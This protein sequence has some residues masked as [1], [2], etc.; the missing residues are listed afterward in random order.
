MSIMIIGIQIIL[1]FFHSGLK[2]NVKNR[3]RQHL[4]RNLTVDN[5]VK[6]YCMNSQNI[7]YILSL[8]CA[9]ISQ[10]TCGVAFV[11]LGHVIYERL[12]LIQWPRTSVLE[13]VAK[14]LYN[15]FK[16]KFIYSLRLVN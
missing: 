11:L 8:Y 12:S 14:S 6:N 9:T 13:N 2:G 1:F 15:K 7:H 16:L 10:L 5:A 4:N 3:E